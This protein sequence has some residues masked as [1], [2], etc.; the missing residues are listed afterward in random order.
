M[1]LIG[2]FRFDIQGEILPCHGLCHFNIFE[3]FPVQETHSMEQICLKCIHL[4]QVFWRE[5]WLH[6]INQLINNQ[7]NH[8][9]LA[10]DLRLNPMQGNICISLEFSHSPAIK[11]NNNSFH[12]LGDLN[13]IHEILAKIVRVH[14]HE[15]KIKPLCKFLHCSI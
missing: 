10:V 6:I 3:D 1:F 8:V 12:S 14:L 2:S 9:L 4:H 11:A 15:W 13:S 5:E 7:S